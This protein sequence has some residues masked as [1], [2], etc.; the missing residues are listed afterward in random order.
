MLHLLSFMAGVAAGETPA[1]LPPIQRDLVLVEGEVTGLGTQVASGA[2]EATVAVRGVYC[3]SRDWVGKSF[4]DFSLVGMADRR[5]LLALPPL[6]VGEAGVWSL[7]VQEGRLIGVNVG[8]LGFTVRARKKQTERYRELVKLAEAV[9]A[10]CN[11]PAAV[12]PARI[13]AL[14]AD[15]TPEIAG[16]A[17]QALGTWEGVETDR[18]FRDLVQDRALPIAAQVAL[19]EVLADEFSI[20]HRP[21]WVGSD[22][23]RR[24]LRDW[25]TRELHSF[26]AT[27]VVAR[28]SLSKQAR[29]IDDALYLDLV[30]DVA[31]NNKLQW[32]QP[33]FG[34]SAAY[35][36]RTVPRRVDDGAGAFRFL[37]D[38]IESL[39]RK[40]PR[41][42]AAQ[43]FVHFKSLI[44]AELAQ[45]I[46]LREKEK[47]KDVAA[48]LD[49]SIAKFK[50][51]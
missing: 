42:A 44:P 24:R 22:E 50:A 51:S 23:R 3:G 2:V 27:S 32:A 9:E 33:L 17:V 29:G 28:L 12:R 45:I 16:W 36:I 41:L 25:V 35:Q 26:E 34:E 30:K 46:A 37:V 11:A 21:D 7:R 6:E 39:R 18:L 15:K 49:E 13:A 38:L 40:E 20:R 5:G 4:S 14:A 10:V 8:K 43:G 48:A 47:D 31:R 19:D 1:D